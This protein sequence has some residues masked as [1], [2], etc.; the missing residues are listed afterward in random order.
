MLKYTIFGQKG[1]NCLLDKVGRVTGI[2]LCWPV[3]AMWLV[4]KWWIAVTWSEWR[5]A[6]VSKSKHV[7]PLGP[8]ACQRDRK[9]EERAIVWRWD[10]WTD[11][12][13]RWEWLKGKTLSRVGKINKQSC[14]LIFQQVAGYEMSRAASS[15]RWPCR[16][17]S[18]PPE[19][20]PASSVLLSS[21]SPK[22][23]AN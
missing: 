7:L 1:E 15:G 22:L 21:S 2:D 23:T 12:N 10:R 17:W 11:M 9:T 4:N 18:P 20:L 8:S 19:S 3:D 13:S 6:T 5:K 14:G 16:D